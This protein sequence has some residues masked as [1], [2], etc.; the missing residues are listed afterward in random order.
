MA[1][2][3]PRELARV[4][5]PSSSAYFTSL[6][7]ENLRC[8]G[9]KQTLALTDDDGRPARWTI[10][11][12]ENGLGKTTLLQLL[13]LA[14]GADFLGTAIDLFRY[15][16][17][18]PPQRFDLTR[19]GKVGTATAEMMRDGRLVTLSVSV[20]GGPPRLAT[21]FDDSEI[22]VC[23]SG[24]GRRIG[25][26]RGHRPER[27][28]RLRCASLFVDSGLRNAEDWLLQEDY[29]AAKEGGD[30]AASRRLERVKHMLVRLLPDVS[31]VRVGE[32]KRHRATSVDFKTPYGWVPLEGLSLG[33][34]SLIAWMVDFASVM[35]ERYPRH[36]DPLAQPAI[37]L[38]DEIDLHLHPRWQRDLI[39]YL[40]ERFPR[41]QFIATA[42]SPLI[43]QAAA[44]ANVVVLKRDGD[45][46]V[47][48]NNPE[49]VRN[50]R[51]DQILTSDLYGLPSARP[52]HLDALLE[53]RRELL[54]KPK[55]TIAQKKRLSEIDAEI[56][57]LPSGESPE[58]RE[59]MALI[60][61]VSKDQSPR[62]RPRKKK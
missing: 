5:L 30:G 41:T 21:N 46:V 27:A 29:A 11:L 58:Q 22:P 40:T 51:I 36:A 10:V 34:K 56:G 25:D 42:H 8:F 7:V 18:S 59:A 6:T 9:S 37:V 20:L 49:N 54:T 53:A 55:L 31:D 60:L 14:S 4:P 28:H 48:E 32:P 43:V 13:G 3:N 17:E 24:A 47:I 23:G 62:K 33:Y 50:W 44:D 52:P 1:M 35:F 61:R 2:K 15:H 12:G 19:R 26:A 16:Y 39:G 38:I 57:G 45:Q